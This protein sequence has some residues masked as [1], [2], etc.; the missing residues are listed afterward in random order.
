MWPILKTS[1][2][3]EG[4]GLQWGSPVL[5]FIFWGVEARAMKKGLIVCIIHVGR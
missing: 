5:P 4:T 1:W 2:I 3:K